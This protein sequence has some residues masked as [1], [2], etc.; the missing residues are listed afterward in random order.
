GQL[1]ESQDVT[2]VN[3]PIAA[4]LIASLFLLPEVGLV[5]TAVSQ[6]PV[7]KSSIR[8]FDTA[9]P[10][11]APLAAE[12]LSVR[13]GWTQI[14]EDILDHGFKGD[15]ILMND[16][17]ALTFHRGASGIGVHSLG[18]GVATLRTTLGPS[19]GTNRPLLSSFSVV[20]NNAALGIVD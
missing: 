1:N 6:E 18:P 5:A 12:A 17:V 13:P 2:K 9:T 11:P 7:A 16:R 4:I 8:L 10:S 15:A 3:S 20:E 14:N 19:G